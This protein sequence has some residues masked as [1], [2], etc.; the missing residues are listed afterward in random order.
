ML[1]MRLTSLLRR[2]FKVVNLGKL[3]YAKGLEEQKKFV[4]IVKKAK[5]QEEAL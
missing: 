4:E 2:S 3:S 5:D 1:I